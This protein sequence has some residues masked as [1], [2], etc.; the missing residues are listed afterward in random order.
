MA[1]YNLIG[2]R[3]VAPS[4]GFQVKDPATGGPVGLCALASPADADAAVAHALAA[5][6]DWERTTGRGAMLAQ[7]A[8][9][10]ERESET[11]ARLLT[12]EQGKPL[13]EALAEVRRSVA[14]F[15]HFAEAGGVGRVIADD[16]TRRIE[17]LRRPVGPVLAITPWNFPVSLMVWKL[18]PALAMGNPVIV[19]PS[20]FAPLTA[21]ALVAAIAPC[22]PAGVLQVLAGEA[23][24]A[25][26]L[27]EHDG[28]AKIAFTGSTATGRAIMAVAGPALKRVTLELGG[29]DAAILLDDCDVDAVAG[30]LYRSA[31]ANCGQVCIAVKRVFVPRKMAGQLA[32]ALAAQA[33]GA[34]VG[35]GL[36]PTTTM[37][38]LNN[39]AQLRRVRD[40]LS[41]GLRDGGQIVAGGEAI[42]GEGNFHQPTIVR[43]VPAESALVE[44]EQFGPVLP[45]VAYDGL[46]DAIRWVE[47]G[48]YGLGGS[49]WGS[50]TARAE[51]VARRI[52]SGMVWINHHLETRPDVPFGG[53]KASGIGSENGI[54]VLAEYSRPQVISTWRS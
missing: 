8:A 19:K 12:A 28:I 25:R 32:D 35:H 11:L 24:V 31:F 45:L 17:V 34:V 49:V 27:V 14:W 9:V 21:Q 1:G 3:A 18:A 26:R 36:D 40:L 50:D 6:P 51:S 20:P 2:G 43:D 48:P 41:A 4:P 23:D 42:S 10:V 29:N 16:A 52:T 46:D 53:A 30:R 15:L 47:R 13:A 38:P 54:E 7:A 33:A 22:F 5:A 39:A 44:E 37:G